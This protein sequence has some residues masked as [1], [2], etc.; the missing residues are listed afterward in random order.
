MRKQSLLI[1]AGLA[2]VLVL[3]GSWSVRQQ[4]PA[5][6]LAEVRK[7]LLP[8]LQETLGDVVGV[9][10]RAAGDTVILEARQ[11]DGGWVAANKG[12]YPLKT[13]RLRELLEA[14]AEAEFQEAKTSNPQQ[15]HHLGLQD[16][17]EEDSK[18]LHITI[19]R[20]GQPAL[21]VLIGNKAAGWNTSYA[22]LLSDP[23]SWVLDR[24]ITVDRE[25]V[26]WI[27]QDV[28]DIDLDRVQSV[29]H[30]A[31]DGET[32]RISKEHPDQ[33]VFDVDAIP[34]GKVLT[35]EAVP[36]VIADVIDNLRLEDVAPA[37]GFPWPQD[38]TYLGTFRTF[39]GLVIT[40][41]AQKRD[42]EHF[43]ALDVAYD[44]AGRWQA[45]GTGDDGAAAGEAGEAAS[46]G[47]ADTEGAAGAAQGEDA[48]VAESG[49][50]PEVE[51][52]EADAAT[53]VMLG[54]EEAEAEAA[55]LQK[56]LAGWVFRIPEYRYKGFIKRIGEIV[57]NEETGSGDEGDTAGTGA[58]APSPG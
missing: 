52:M 22:R 8:D 35:Y 50:G 39:D 21:D 5:D 2:V 25:T 4:Q 32:L 1:L 24:E 45:P 53:R 49:D 28:I 10:I 31:P 36:E 37:D 57:K 18:A 16:I 17:K 46:A 41:R 14:L 42:D 55:A 34:E 19:E 44:P 6:T 51:E 3:L 29:E 40:S 15:Y 7:P 38:S 20:K 9:T 12:G 30:T 56:K 13:A 33:P 11:Q 43:V 47:T 23:Q 26:D 48:A 54:E 58:E 27:E